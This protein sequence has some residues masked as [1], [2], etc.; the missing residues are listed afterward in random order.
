MQVK[1]E[2]AWPTPVTLVAGS[3]QAERDGLYNYGNNRKPTWE[4][5]Y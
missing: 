4:K 5:H 1:L 2:K 3:L